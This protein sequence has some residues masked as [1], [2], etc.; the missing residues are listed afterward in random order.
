MVGIKG[1]S[2]SGGARPGA[3]R[4]S[5]DRNIV[6]RTMISEEA[7][8]RLDEIVKESGKTI[9]D[10]IE[11]LILKDNKQYIMSKTYRES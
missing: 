9:R 2:G 11:E 4:R 6:L 7:K 1:K 5:K 10:I 8:K 3:G